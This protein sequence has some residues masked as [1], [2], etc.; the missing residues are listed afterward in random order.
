VPKGKPRT[1]LGV[2]IDPDIK[3]Q[4]KRFAESKHWSMS[5]AAEILIKEGLNR[6]EAEGKDKND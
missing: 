3:E 6:A 2:A 5:Q 4:L 1:N